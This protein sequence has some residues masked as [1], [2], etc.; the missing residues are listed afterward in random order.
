MPKASLAT[1]ALPVSAAKAVELFGRDIAA[2]RIRRRIPQRLMAE[3]MMVS[4]DTVQRL[5][6]GDP[7]VGLGVVATALWVLGLVGRLA[8]LASPDH[9]SIGKTEDIK[10]LPRRVRTPAS[11]TDLDF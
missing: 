9:D 3:K 8:T 1:K 7:G 10:R 11:K 6:R 5:E 2:A 4:F